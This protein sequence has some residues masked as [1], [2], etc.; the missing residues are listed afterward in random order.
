VELAHRAAVCGGKACWLSTI[1]RPVLH[2][3]I[4]ALQDM[5][6]QVRAFDPAGMDQAK[7]LLPD[8]R[9]CDGPYSCADGADGVIIV[10][11]WERFRALDLERM[12]E[13]MACPVL[14][15]LRNVYS[16]EDMGKHGFI[17]VGVGR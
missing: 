11:E 7:P 13:C 5:G 14:V 3:L 4:I 15:D 9:Y 6:A 16:G 17:Y 10:T 2:P 8:V 12:K 1:L